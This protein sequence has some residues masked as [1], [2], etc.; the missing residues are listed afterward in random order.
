MLFRSFSCE[1]PVVLRELDLYQGVISGY[2]AGCKDRIAM[3]KTLLTLKKDQTKLVDL[4]QKAKAAAEFYSEDR[5]AKIWL[6]Y[7]QKQ[8]GK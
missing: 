5:L 8:V 4:T 3:E 1:T 6:E 7:Y 2:Y